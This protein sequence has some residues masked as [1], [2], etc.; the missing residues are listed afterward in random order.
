M[1]EISRILDALAQ[2]DPHAAGELLPLVY[3]DLLPLAAQKLACEAS[4][5]TLQPTA[6]VH[7]AYLC[8]ERP[9]GEKVNRIDTQIL[10]PRPVVA[11]AQPG[12]AKGVI[13]RNSER[14]YDDKGMKAP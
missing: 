11:I 5:Q 10:T 14:H 8:R 4:G 3:Q 1:S 12:L 9:Q 6:L 13:D 2:G 7:E